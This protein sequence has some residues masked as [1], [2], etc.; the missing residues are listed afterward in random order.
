MA[1]HEGPGRIGPWP[2]TIALKPGM[3]YSNE[4]GYYK[5][6]SYGIRIE[7]LV[8]VR[9]VDSPGERNMLGFEE[10]TLAPLDRN[11]V[12]LSL[13]DERELD[14]LNAYH[15]RVRDEFAPL[16]EGSDRAWLEAQTEPITR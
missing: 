15:A 16:L 9:E 2:N 5:A 10:L 4:P 1:V 3:I 6:D 11:M 12:D 8:F 7:N 14:W 13:L